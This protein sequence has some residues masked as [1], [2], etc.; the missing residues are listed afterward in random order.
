MRIF[1]SINF[2]PEI[3]KY[4]EEVGRG[5]V[6]A[7][8]SLATSFHLTLKF[9][10]EVSD[11]KVPEI[12][13][14]LAQISF[15]KFNLELRDAGFFTDRNGHIRVIWVGLSAPSELM[16]LQKEVE[17]AVGKY[18]AIKTENF[19]PHLTLSRVKFAN[20][21]DLSR[22]IKNA[23]IKRFGMEVEHFSLM[24]SQLSATGPTYAELAKFGDGGSF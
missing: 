3:K 7:R 4:L 9:L 12:K 17:I 10:G 21:K 19:V 11:E 18:G 24:Q 22:Q 8:Q 15:K 16:Q 1:V 6:V 13:E 14:K 23:K 20:D 5:F 2:T